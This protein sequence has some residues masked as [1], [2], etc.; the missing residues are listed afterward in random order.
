MES[1]TNAHKISMGQM[2]AR[3]TSE[4]QINMD[5]TNE[6]T[7]KWGT[8]LICILCH[9]AFTDHSDPALIKESCPWFFEMRELIGERPNI[10]PSGLGNGESKTDMSSFLDGADRNDDDRVGSPTPWG[11]VE[12]DMDLPADGDDAD[13][14]KL[15]WRQQQE[16]Q[17][18]SQ[19]HGDIRSF[20]TRSNRP[21]NS[22][23]A[24]RPTKDNKKPKA[25]EFADIVEAEEVTRQ[26]QL[27]LAKAKIET[28]WAK[29]EAKKAE[30]VYKTQRM[31]DRSERRKEKAQER[32]AKIQLREERGMGIM[33]R[34]I[35]IHILRVPRPHPPAPR[36]RNL[37]Q[38]CLPVFRHLLCLSSLVTTTV[39]AALASYITNNHLQTPM[40][41]RLPMS[42][43]HFHPTQATIRSTNTRKMEEKA[44]AHLRQAHSM[45]LESRTLPFN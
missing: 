34:P 2:G 22:K 18:R 8:Y 7:N 5:A 23:P 44:W 29:A 12:E 9:L 13:E 20:Q 45:N 38:M 35:N 37:T 40:N 1:I 14:G 15:K 36:V 41:S 27:D 42:P 11:I 31:V 6:F 39:R 4:D 16:E 24:M 26:K 33:G 3:I 10:V 19:R 43:E 17:S 25:D 28:K 21:G 32:A 30:L